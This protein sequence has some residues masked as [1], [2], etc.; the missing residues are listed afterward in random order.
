D[1]V[2]R[3]V[4]QIG[5]DDN[6]AVLPYNPHG[7]F[8]TQNGRNDPAP[9]AVT[10]VPG[11]PIYDANPAA[12]PVAD[13]D[14]YFAGQYPSGFNSLPGVLSVPN[15][16]PAIAWERGHTAGDRFKRAHWNLSAGHLVTGARFRLSVEF[17]TGGFSLDGVTQPGFGTHN[18]EIWFRNGNGGSTPLRVETMT[19]PTEVVLE[20]SAASV[21]AT[22]GA[23]TLEII[24]TGPTAPGMAIWIRYDY[25]R[26]EWLPPATAGG[27]S[28]AALSAG[29][30][31]RSAIGAFAAGS[32]SA[33]VGALRGGARPVDGLTYA[34]LSYDLSDPAPENLRPVVEVSRDLVRWDEAEVLVL[35]DE[36]RDG[37]RWRT[38]QDRVPAEV[39]GPRY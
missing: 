4:W 23:N 10:R 25:L 33:G 24:R 37:R 14:F 27:S 17:A 13:D 9:G 3:T 39:A 21:G 29:P 15:D 2:A 34:T 30:A 28:I 26:L 32:A 12:N 22:L 18:M 20:F 38:V 31:G 19:G 6:P 1:P 11:D 16:E 5:T 35:S 8:T 36:V 7:E